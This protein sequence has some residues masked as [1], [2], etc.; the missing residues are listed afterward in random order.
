MLQ[1][2]LFFTEADSNVAKFLTKVNII[3]GLL[4]A[5]VFSRFLLLTSAWLVAVLLRYCVVYLSHFHQN[6][7]VCLPNPAQLIFIFTAPH[8]T[9]LV[10]A[11]VSRRPPQEKFIFLFLLKA[12][13][14]WKWNYSLIWLLLWKA[15]WTP[16]RSTTGL[17][18]FANS[19]R[20]IIYCKF[21][22]SYY[23][24]TFGLIVSL[25]SAPEIPLLIFW[26]LIFF[27]SFLRRLGLFLSSYI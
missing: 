3:R 13:F 10:I 27:P 14:Y 17:I 25:L 23:S 6:S 7:E 9:A 24:V 21:V 18:L 2:N 16:A 19:I 11:N 22:Q 12:M 15:I 20:F 1:P 26:H 8:Y 4:T 5:L